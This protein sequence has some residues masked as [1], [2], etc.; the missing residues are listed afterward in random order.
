MSGVSGV[1]GLFMART[2]TTDINKINVVAVPVE[3][4]QSNEPERRHTGSLSTVTQ[5]N[6]E[7]ESPV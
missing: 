1:P 7:P 5:V 3:I 6:L 4:S 2:N